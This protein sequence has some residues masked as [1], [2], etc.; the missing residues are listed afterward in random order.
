MKSYEPTR[1]RKIAIV[2]PNKAAYSETF[3]RSHIENLPAR[4]EE[5]NYGHWSCPMYA[6]KERSLLELEVDFGSK[7][8]R[9]TQRKILKKTPAFFQTQSLINFLQHKQCEVVL[10]EYGITGVCIMDA[11][12][13]AGIPLVVHFHGYDAYDRSILDKFGE[14]YKI[15]FEQASAVIAVSRAMERQL[16]DLGVSKSKLIYN[17]YGVDI[18][19]FAPADVAASAPQFVTIGR[20]VDKK[21]P[22]LTL[23]AFQKVVDVCPEAK[24][25]MIG[26]GYLL[27]A[28]KQIAKTIG[29]AKNVEF[30]GLMNHREIAAILSKARAF[31]Q[32]SVQTSYGDSEGTPLAILEAGATAIPV[33]STRHAGIPDV[34]IHEQ[35]GLLV[36]EGDV[37]GMARNIITLAKDTDLASKLGKAAR[38]RIVEKF[39]TKQSINNLWKVLNST[40]QKQENSQIKAS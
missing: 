23:L 26:D 25:T 13:E 4:V 6:Q 32:H 10:A 2:H 36:E 27:E 11:C 38:E 9:L 29:I 18:S 5:I 35:T 39:S 37:D 20:F 31:L 40:I 12:K 22:Y 1:K 17:P 33:I 3:I 21:A 19:L 14:A 28:C 16:I 8:Q 15:L 24:L 34:V 7:L 30:T